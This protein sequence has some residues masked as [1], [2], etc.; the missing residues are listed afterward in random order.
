MSRSP[1]YQKLLN[2]PEWK[3]LRAWKLSVNPLC[4]LCQAEGYVRL[5]V[6]VH[7]KRPVEGAS[8]LIGRDGMV[9]RCYSRTNLQSLCVQC[10]IR[11]HQEMKSHKKK[12][13]QANKKRNLQRWADSHP[14]PGSRRDSTEEG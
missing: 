1:E 13:V 9:E 5:A 12:E 4:E 6:D 8:R 2:S 14:A 10:H 11:V 3:K 7:H